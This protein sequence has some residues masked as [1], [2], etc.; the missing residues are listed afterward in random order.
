[1]LKVFLWYQ[2]TQEKVKNVWEVSKSFQTFYVTRKI[3]MKFISSGYSLNLVFVCYVTVCDVRESFKI[4]GNIQYQLLQWR[5]QRFARR[6][7]SPQTRT[8]LRTNVSLTGS[9]HSEYVQMVPHSLLDA[10]LVA[11]VLVNPCSGT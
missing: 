8:Y 6:L 1:M 3:W 10:F 9:I 11:L 7:F 5:P 2:K 4:L